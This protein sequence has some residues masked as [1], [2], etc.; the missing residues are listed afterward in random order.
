MAKTSS[1]AVVIQSGS[2]SC[3][4]GLSGQDFPSTVFPSVVGRPRFKGIT[5]GVGQKAC[6]VGHEALQRRNVVSLKSPIERGSVR[7]WDGLER[8]WHHTFENELRVPPEEHPVLLTETPLSPNE[9]REKMA[10]ILFETFNVPALY[11]ANQ[12]KL[13][14]C[15]SG[16]LTGMVVHIGHGA[17]YV[18]P[19]SEGFAVK[20]ATLRVDT[21]GQDLTEYLLDV[22]FAR[23]LIAKTPADY[24]LARGIKEHLCR[25]SLNFP[26]EVTSLATDMSLGKDY[27]LPDGKV[28]KVGKEQLQCPEALLR[29]SVLGVHAPGVSQLVRESIEKCDSSLRENMYSNI[30]LSGGSSLFPGLEE[31][32]KAELEQQMSPGRATEVNIIAPPERRYS[33]WIGGAI[34]PTLSTFQHIW[35]LKQEY[36]ESGPGI[37]HQKCL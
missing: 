34:L 21:A 6:F 3:K 18:V 17:S 8:I 23:G 33:C 15:S 13:S 31:R 4:A 27:R 35:V 9:R 36:Q 10:Q 19:I 7:D 32:L 30:V 14:M 16:R 20:H 29:P 26:Q 25:V 24:E 22:L 5:P 11:L 28:I 2:C 12:A 1:R 37:V